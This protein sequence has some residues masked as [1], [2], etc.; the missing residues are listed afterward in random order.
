MSLVVTL[1]VTAAVVVVLARWTASHQKGPP[2]RDTHR[3]IRRM[4]ERHR[5]TPGLIV[6]IFWPVS[7]I[8]ALKRTTEVV[9]IYEKTFLGEVHRVACHINGRRRPVWVPLVGGGKRKFRCVAKGEVESTTHLTID[10]GLQVHALLTCWPA[11]RGALT[12]TRQRTEWTIELLDQA[13]N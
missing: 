9:L 6:D 11:K 1:A 2:R 12:P 4:S 8:Y 7:W 10:V 3:A 13:N 5:A